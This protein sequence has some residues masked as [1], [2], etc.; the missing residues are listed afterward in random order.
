MA[1][2]VST[3]GERHL[4]AI[5]LMIVRISILEGVLLDLVTR[6]A[7]IDVFDALIIFEHQQFSSKVQS[8][9]ALVHS[10]KLRGRPDLGELTDTLNRVANVGERRNTVVHAYWAVDSKEGALAVRF[11]A[12]GQLERK[13]IPMPPEEIERIADDAMRIK[14][15][16][17]EQINRLFPNADA[18]P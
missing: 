4:K 7:R 14:D 16:L 15:I 18:V 2:L 12:R 8:V 11:S 6:L 1:D 9:K 3:L 10:F 5:G 13:R 17:T